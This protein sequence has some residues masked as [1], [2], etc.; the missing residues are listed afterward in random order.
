MVRCPKCNSDLLMKLPIHTRLVS[1]KKITRNKG[2]DNEKTY[3]RKQYWRRSPRR[4]VCKSCGEIFRYL[5]SGKVE[6]QGSYGKSIL[7]WIK[8]DEG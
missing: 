7:E 8:H 6:D 3:V 5:S 1:E 4:W 2:M